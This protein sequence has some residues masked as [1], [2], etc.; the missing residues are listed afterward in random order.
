MKTVYLLRH[1]KSSW[2]D[3]SLSDYQRPLNPRGRKAAPEVGAYM[4]EEGFIPHLTLCSSARRTVETWE[5]VKEALGVP[6]EEE[7]TRSLYLADPETILS[8]LQGVPEGVESVLVVGHNPGMEEAIGLLAGEWN[9]AAFRKAREK[10]PTGSLAVLRFP[11]TARWQELEAGS[12]FL[13]RFVRP[14]D[15]SG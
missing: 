14:A 9:A 12:G 5:S 13:E 8:L 15:L 7:F 10:V 6:V 3:V 4:R 2:D 1:A 11:A